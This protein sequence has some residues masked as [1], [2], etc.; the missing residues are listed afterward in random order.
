VVLN[1]FSIEDWMPDEQV[2]VENCTSWCNVMLNVVPAKIAGKWRTPTGV[3]VTLTQQYQMVSGTANPA[4]GQPVAVTGRLRG[5]D[6]TLSA[7]NTAE[8]TGRVNGNVIEGTQQQA[9]GGAPQPLTLT[10][11]P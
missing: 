11:V 9:G 1:T 6:V 5:Y 7:A 8:F 4:G 2:T 3:E 10:R